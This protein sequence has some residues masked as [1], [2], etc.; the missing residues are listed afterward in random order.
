M[1]M[2]S[3]GTDPRI[4]TPPAHSSFPVTSAASS[5]DESRT[6]TLHGNVYPLARAEFDQGVVDPATRLDRMLL[7]LNSSSAQQADLDALLAAQQDPHSPL[8]HQWLTPNEFGVRFGASDSNLAQVTAWLT[9]HGFTV[10]E[11][12][13]GRRLVVFS[14]SAAQVSAAFRTERAHLPR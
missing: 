5:I 10:S 11:I 2:A 7:V 3:C 1:L 12:P 8:Y 14:G 4:E 6:V 9:A 13:I